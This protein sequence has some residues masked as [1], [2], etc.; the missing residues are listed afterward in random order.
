MINLQQPTDSNM[1]NKENNQETEAQNT[2]ETPN[3][4]ARF[5]K[6]AVIGII[7]AVIAWIALSF[8][9][10]IAWAISVLAIISSCIGLKA[11]SR[12]LRN[13]AITALVASSVLLIVVSAFLLV[14]LIGI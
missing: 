7:L 9:G 3:P 11:P 4:R 14:F 10:R 12:T 13:T 8:E 1:D 5:S 6:Y 2:A